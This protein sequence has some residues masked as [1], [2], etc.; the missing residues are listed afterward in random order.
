MTDSIGKHPRKNKGSNYFAT[1]DISLFLNSVLVKTTA[2]YTSD[3]NN[4]IRV[5]KTVDK[6]R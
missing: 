1:G 6:S 4:N 2:Q 3:N 5:K